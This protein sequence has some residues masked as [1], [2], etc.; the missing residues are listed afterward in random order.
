VRG[1]GLRC[2][3]CGK[4]SFAMQNP[5][6]RWRKFIISS[7]SGRERGKPVGGRDATILLCDECAWSPF[8][9]VMYQGRRILK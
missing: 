7:W 6:P 5:P 4:V 9:I 2:Y 8:E 3:L 1:S